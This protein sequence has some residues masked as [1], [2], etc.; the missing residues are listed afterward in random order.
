[1]RPNSA[2]IKIHPN[3]TLATSLLRPSKT[4]DDLQIQDDRH[5]LTKLKIKQLHNYNWMDLSL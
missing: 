5:F 3:P 2:H 1:M 4:Q